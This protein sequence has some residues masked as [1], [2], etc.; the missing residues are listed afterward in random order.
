[1]SNRRRA[2]SPLPKRA[3]K[4]HCR[5]S[6]DTLR[7]STAHRRRFLSTRGLLPVVL[8]HPEIQLD[9]KPRSILRESREERISNPDRGLLGEIDF[10]PFISQSY[11]SCPA[12]AGHIVWFHFQQIHRRQQRNIFNR[13]E[14]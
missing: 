13:S 7:Q 5:K 2:P 11:R 10:G 1:M 3:P 6:S 4:D 12:V 14:P 8:C 9:T